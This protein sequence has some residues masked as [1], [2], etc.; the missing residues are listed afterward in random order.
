MAQTYNVVDYGAVGDGSTVN[1]VFIQAAIDSCFENGGGEV[2]FSGGDFVTG[3][4]FLKSNVMLNIESGASLLGSPSIADYPD[5]MPQLP[6]YVNNY[7]NK[8]LV[9]AEDAEN[10]GFTGSGTFDGQG[11]NFLNEEHRPFGFRFVSCSN[12]LIEDVS[13]RNSGFWMMHN[14]DIDSLVIRNIDIFNHGNAN[15]DGINIDGCRNVLV[16]NC[17]VD[18]NDD[19]MVLK[20]TGPANCED[21]E[22]RNCTVATWS[23]ALKIG[24]ETH[25]GFRNIHLHDLTVEWSSLAVSFL[26]VGAGSCGINLAIVDGGFMENVTV[27]NVTMEGIETAIFVRL[28]NRGRVYEAGMPAPAVGYLRDVTIRNVEATVESN[29]TSSIT[30]IPGFYAKNIQ[31]EDVTIEFPGGA[32]DP[33]PSFTV[34]ENEDAKPDNDIFGST[35]PSYGLYV[36][37]VDSLQLTNVCFNWEDEDARQGIILDDVTNSPNYEA[38][39]TDGGCAQI[40][41]GIEEVEVDFNVWVDDASSV[42]FS[43]DVPQNMNLEL[44]NATGGLILSS[45]ISGTSFQLP[46]LSCGVYLL[47]V[48]T[49]KMEK[50]IRFVKK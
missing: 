2:L 22:I 11:I 47:K 5:A 16:E 36:R 23:R 28:G 19:P 27:E 41:S 15:N 26:G 14:F 40:A 20:T 9:Y 31:L 12:V 44:Y 6:T 29:I 42:H 49:R 7:T 48:R 21:V 34:P 17:T 1:T 10:I 45:S 24:T 4:I 3:T 32:N 18:S 46:Q 25:A 8:T 30:G 13:F 43:G 38:V 50:A 35:L 39:G 33:G 37:H